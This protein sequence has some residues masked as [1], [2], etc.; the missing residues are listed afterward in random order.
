MNCSCSSFHGGGAAIFYIPYGTGTVPLDIPDTQPYDVVNYRMNENDGDEAVSL[1][2]IRDTLNRPDGTPPLRELARGKK[3]AVIM[4][5][6]GTRLCPS[7]IILPLLL[8]ELNLGG[9]H[10]DAITILI[11]LGMHRQHTPQEM[12]RLVGA[13]VYTRVRVLNHSAAAEDCIYLGTTSAGTPVEIN[14]IAV[15]ADL[16]IVTGNIEP[17]AMAGVSGGVKAVIPGIASERCIQH[18]HSLSM[19][20]RTVPGETDNPVHRDMA[21]ALRFINIDFMLNVIVNH[22]QHILEAVAGHVIQAHRTA[23]DKA[24][25]RFI[26][27]SQTDYDVTVVS[28]GGHPKD[29]QMYQSI[30]ALRN[31]SAITKPGGTILMAAE[32]A[33][34]MGNGTLSLWV[35]TMRDRK[36]AVDKLKQQFQLGAHKLLHLDDVLSRHTVYLHSSIPRPI[37]ELLGFIPAENLQSAFHLAL[38]N[39]AVKLAVMPFGSLTYPQVLQKPQSP[40]K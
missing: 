28:P 17:H 12:E 11:A 40:P 13:R 10:D 2:R 36:R 35:E 4:I 30:K 8:D 26:V 3:H 27:P 39:K 21:E 16:R 15:E 22:K 37:V 38:T 19:N 34:M 32:C 18:N 5:S 33:E 6:D 24:G 9:V 7:H 25:A 31:A 1:T 29:M 23:I 20:G 14:R